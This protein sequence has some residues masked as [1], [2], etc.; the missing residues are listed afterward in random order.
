MIRRHQRR[1]R[2][3]RY[4]LKRSGLTT[5]FLTFRPIL[6]SFVT[7]ENTPS[8]RHDRA[9]VTSS[10]VALI[11]SI[12]PR[13][14]C[15]RAQPRTALTGASIHGRLARKKSL[16][17][18]AIVSAS[19]F[20][21]DG[22]W[23]V[24]YPIRLAFPVSTVLPPPSFSSPFSPLPPLSL[25]SSSSSTT[26]HPF[27]LSLSLTISLPLSSSGASSSSSVFSFSFIRRPILVHPPLLRFVW[28][29]DGETRVH[30][31]VTMTCVILRA[32]VRGTEANEK[33][34]E[35]ERM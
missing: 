6:R 19:L 11:C 23:R 32:G 24:P 29:S 18:I 31:F 34:R 5:R 8:W 14:S 22:V 28:S 12:H 15:A 4:D 3:S 33:K 20:H 30:I 35:S 17:A 26:S 2:R 21:Y 7:A 1:I 16:C 13:R 27:S 9:D 25:S 10:D